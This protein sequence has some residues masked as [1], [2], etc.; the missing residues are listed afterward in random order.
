MA[1]AMRL[2]GLWRAAKDLMTTKRGRR[3]LCV[4]YNSTLVRS[5]CRLAVYTYFKIVDSVRQ[6]VF[7]F[8]FL[9]FLQRAATW[10]VG[11]AN[12]RSSREQA[13]QLGFC[14]S[15]LSPAHDPA[16]GGEQDLCQSIGSLR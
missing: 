7:L 13:G 12:E 16:G 9:F 10:G 14:L 5:A 6:C 8:F 2:L 4:F 15:V 3:D 11:K 1:S